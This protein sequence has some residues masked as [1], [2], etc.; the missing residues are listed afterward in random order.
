MRTPVITPAAIAKTI[1]RV[2]E[3]QM[4]WPS[5]MSVNVNATLIAITAMS[6]RSIPRPMTTSAIATARMPSTDTLR[7]S[8]TRLP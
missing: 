6:D 8:V 1:P 7:M 2:S 5:R 3:Y 4:G